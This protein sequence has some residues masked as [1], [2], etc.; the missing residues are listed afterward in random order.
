LDRPDV[1]YYRET[2][3]EQTEQGVSAEPLQLIVEISQGRGWSSPLHI[4]I[5]QSSFNQPKV[6]KH[7]KQVRLGGGGGGDTQVVY[8]RGWARAFWGLKLANWAFCGPEIFWCPDLGTK[9]WAGCLLG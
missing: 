5:A 6:E 7:T 3:G 1:N 9:I 2:R 4:C 8:E